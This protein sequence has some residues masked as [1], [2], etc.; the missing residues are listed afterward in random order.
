MKT[1]LSKLS[2][3]AANNSLILNPVDHRFPNITAD[4]TIASK[5]WQVI[6]CMSM[7]FDGQNI[8]TLNSG[9]PV[10]QAI[11]H[12][13]REKIKAG[14]HTSIAAW[15]FEPPR[16]WNNPDHQL[17]VWHHKVY[18]LVL[19]KEK[20]KRKEKRKVQKKD[21]RTQKKLNSFSSL[22]YIKIKGSCYLVWKPLIIRFP[23][24]LPPRTLVRILI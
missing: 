21:T 14:V 23:L 19:A 12:S 10:M 9:V 13:R 18:R 22:A 2:R 7:S 5:R 1:H 6:N 16:E 17:W 15:S 8:G 4:F 11:V 24:K 20:K 3:C